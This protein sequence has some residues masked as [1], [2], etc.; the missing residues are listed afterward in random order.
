MI[1]KSGLYRPV[2]RRWNL[3]SSSSSSEM[4]SHSNNR[5]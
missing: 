3:S 5:N 4:L 1:G 2:V